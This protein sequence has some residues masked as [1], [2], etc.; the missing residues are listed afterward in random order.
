MGCFASSHSA[1][2]PI[3]LL[4]K[5]GLDYKSDGLYADSFG[6]AADMPHFYREAHKK[7]AKAQRKLSKKG[8]GLRNWENQRRKAARIG[9]PVCGSTYDRDINAAKNIDKAGL[10]ILLAS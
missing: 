1:S 5:I 8:K 9:C 2:V 6:N 10:R 7:L 4:Y 3:R